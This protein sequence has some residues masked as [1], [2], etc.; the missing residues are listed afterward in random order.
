MKINT[1]CPNEDCRRRIEHRLDRSQEKELI[2]RLALIVQCPHCESRMKIVYGPTDDSINTEMMEPVNSVKDTPEELFPAQP[3]DPPPFRPTMSL[4]A[5]TSDKLFPLAD[6]DRLGAIGSE[7]PA[8][9]FELKGET[10]KKENALLAR[11]SEQSQTVQI[12]IVLLLMPLPLVILFWP[13]DSPKPPEG[14]DQIANSAVS[15]ESPGPAEDDLPVPQMVKPVDVGEN[16][17]E[18]APST[19]VD[20]AEVTNETPEESEDSAGENLDPTPQT[21]SI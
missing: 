8:P 16:A 20:S 15:S 11:F 3:S 9:P 17:D 19:K 21:E 14:T 18:D 6:N 7:T 10:E 13:M 12:L 5:H 4:P 2:V 1:R